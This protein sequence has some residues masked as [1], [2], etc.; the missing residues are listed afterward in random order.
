MGTLTAADPVIDGKPAQAWAFEARAG[1]FVT[2]ELMS[3]DFDSY[4]YI[5]GPGLSE[6]LT[7]DDGGEDLNSRLDVSFPNDGVYRVVV[8]SLGGTFG[9]FTLRVH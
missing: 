8:S 1:E 5:V 3:D 6:P 9:M 7:D 4:L 2:I